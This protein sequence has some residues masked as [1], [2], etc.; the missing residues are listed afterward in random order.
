MNMTAMGT[1]GL[2]L[3][4]TALAALSR[5]Q[6][7][8]D[9]GSVKT[10]VSAFFAHYLETLESRDAEAIRTLFVADDR[11]AWFTD[12]VK[13]YS[14]PDDVIAGL[15]VYAHLYF[16]TTLSETRVVP[17]GASLASARSKF[18]T[19]LTSAQPDDWEYEYG[20]VITWLLEKD[21][22]SGEWKVILG[23]TSTPGGPPGDGGQE[24]SR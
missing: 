9:D 16:E 11:F 22:E 2:G 20:G 17:L 18:N 13:S 19:T 6:D 12:G 4:L 15:S 8:A 14:T 24:E 21:P 3:G 7:P 1:V 10:E 5:G 23:H